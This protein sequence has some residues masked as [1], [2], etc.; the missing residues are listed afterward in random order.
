L[1]VCWEKLLQLEK[2]GIRPVAPRDL[3]EHLHNV[4]T[5]PWAATSSD[6][7]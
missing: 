7:L 4:I 6:S 5:V 2:D 1:Q 3:K